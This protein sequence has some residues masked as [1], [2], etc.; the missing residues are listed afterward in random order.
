MGTN[1]NHKTWYITK[2][3]FNTITYILLKELLIACLVVIN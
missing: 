3:I 2:T 1:F